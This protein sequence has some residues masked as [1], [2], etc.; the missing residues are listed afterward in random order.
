MKKFI[1]NESKSECK[2]GGLTQLAEA[3]FDYKIRMK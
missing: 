2:P 3:E 1:E